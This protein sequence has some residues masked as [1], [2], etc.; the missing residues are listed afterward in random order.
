VNGC[1]SADPV[2]SFESS[3]IGVRCT[4][5]QQC[6]ENVT[7][8]KYENLMPGAEYGL[9]FPALMTHE[10]MRFFMVAGCANG[11]QIACQTARGPTTEP[12]I[13]VQVTTRTAM[14]SRLSSES[15]G[16]QTLVPCWIGAWSILRLLWT[17]VH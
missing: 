14:P 10:I 12:P 4:T 15:C 8:C 7:L 13:P 6:V 2:V 16:V 11:V 1:N 17:L 3:A 5:A 9:T